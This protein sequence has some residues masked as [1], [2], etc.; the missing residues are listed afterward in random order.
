MTN[1]RTRLRVT[2]EG[3]DHIESRSDAL[4]E[5]AI[6]RVPEL[7]AFKRPRG[8]GEAFPFDLLILA[9]RE[10][11][12]SVFV[13]GFSSQRSKPHPEE[14]GDLECEVEASLL[15]AA[16]KNPH[17]VVLFLFDADRG[18]GRFLR[19]DARPEPP[20]NAKTVLL[21]FPIENTITADSI[22][23]LATELE[24]ARLVRVG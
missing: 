10:P 4:A 7:L 23:K 13:K 8:A 24:Q 19:L 1:K 12:F 9:D 18:H 14:I 5:L 16:R 17:P 21:T 6:A 3:P 2:T 22:R 11:R 15:R 20:S